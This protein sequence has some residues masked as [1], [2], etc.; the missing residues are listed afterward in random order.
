M[1][2]STHMNEHEK[3]QVAANAAEIYEQFFVP[4]L[5]AEWPKRVLQAANVQT[6]DSVLD[7][8][9]G[10]GVLAREAADRVGASGSVF[11][12]DINE[13]MLA[14]ARQKTPNI[15]WKIGPAES[16]PFKADT[17]DRVVSQFAL[18]FFEDQTKAIAEMG[19]VARPGG[20]VT[21]AVWDSLAATPGYAA[22]AEV[23]DE[24]FGPEVAQSIQA[25]YSLGDRQ[26]L[27]SLFAKAGMNDITIRTIT[28]QARFASIEAWIYT[29]IKGWTLADI[30]DDEGYERLRQHAPQK[31]A[32]FVLAD[33]SVAFD[34]PAHI[35]T[36]AA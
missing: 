14:I 23:L 33:D 20:T 3:G 4:A 16:L 34:A 24:L 15:T 19:R 11:G 5:F 29:D 7:V 2:T 31:L 28:G 13:G 25:P 8:A 18:M 12:V 17:F 1:T 35:I 32:Q 9:C 27:T 10:T 6:G 21:V 30:I 26:K 36:F 22:V